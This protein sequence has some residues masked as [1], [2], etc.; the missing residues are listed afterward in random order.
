MN[1]PIASPQP[2][3]RPFI[4]FYLWYYVAIGAFSPF[5]SLYLATVG[6]DGVQMGLL[7]G[8]TPI[9]SLLVQPIWGIVADV[10]S[11]RRRLLTAACVLSALVGL[12]LPLAYGFAWV[13]LVMLALTLVRTPIQPIA[14]AITLEAIAPHRERYPQIRMW[15]SLSFG[16]AS[17][18]VGWWVV[19]RYVVGTIY[20]FVAAML[21]TAWVSRRLPSSRA[22]ITAKWWEAWDMA[23][24]NRPYLIF[25]LALVL[26]Q[27]THPLA[28]A[29]LPLY[30]KA[31]GAPG[32]VIGAAWGVAAVIELPFMA[33]TP[34]LL[35]RFGKKRV[36]A[37]LT[38][39]VPLRWLLYSYITNPLLILPFQFMHSM[40]ATAYYAA[41]VPLIDD[42]IPPQWRAT[43]QAFYSALSEGIGI[44]GGSL[45]FGW[46]YQ[47]A[48]IGTAFLVGSAVALL[49]WVVLVIGVKGVTVSRVNTS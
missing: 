11:M 7:F 19:D 25:V 31:L 10:L 41:A 17:L 3:L 9:V 15:G 46:L 35:R 14:N 24:G 21:V 47:Q 48:G 30:F 4:V 1:T 39:A 29:Y 8:L 26:L 40:A 34:R 43:G 6:F 16:V 49:G 38:A 37:V 18:A 27:F 28:T 36:L 42:L 13:M 23:R 32:W 44:G 22:S 45:V 20:L 12:V 2:S 33:L 5:I